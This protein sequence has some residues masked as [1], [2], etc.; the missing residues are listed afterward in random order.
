MKIKCGCGETMELVGPYA[1]G[2][3][4]SV[5]CICGTLI[6]YPP[7]SQPEARDPKPLT[8]E[9]LKAR[10]PKPELDPYELIVQL[11]TALEAMTA[12]VV[13]LRQ[14]LEASKDS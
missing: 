12:I 11:S 5:T 2:A 3:T 4:Y 13:D 7:E 14:K 9:H 10:E 1:R 6:E 8:A